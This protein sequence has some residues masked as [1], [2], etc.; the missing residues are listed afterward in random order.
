ML[1]KITGCVLAFLGIIIAIIVIKVQGKKRMAENSCGGSVYFV[2]MI[3]VFSAIMAG[4]AIMCLCFAA[5]AAFNLEGR[6]LA[7]ALLIF[8][9]FAFLELAGYFC[10]MFWMI[11]VNEEAGILVYYRPPFRPLK[12]LIPEITRIQILENRLNS[13]EQY[14]VYRS[15]KKLFEITD[16]MLGYRRLREYLER[17]AETAGESGLYDH[18]PNV[19][20][21]CKIERGYMRAGVVELAEHKEE[22]TV[23]ETAAKKARSGITTLV[24][25]VLD[26]LLIF[27]WDAWMGED[28]QYLFCVVGGVFAAVVCMS[29]FI[30]TALF[31]I[32]VSHHEISVRKGI[33]REVVYT[34]REISKVETK[35]NFIVLYMGGK[36]VAKV[37]KECKNAVYLAEWLDRE[38]S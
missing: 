38:I 12:I 24:V 7:V 5:G 32:S 21:R 19:G 3:P 15:G 11:A 27:N 20:K 29:D 6:R 37:S 18:A 36:R 8:L 10:T 1:Y 22:F 26:F 14:R 34:M 16:M 17:T 2:R 35:G 31:K 4:G 25:L 9:G 30:P 28:P 23:T 13:P 33:R